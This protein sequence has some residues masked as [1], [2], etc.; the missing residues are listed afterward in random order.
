MPESQRGL[1]PSHSTA[2]AKFLKGFHIAINAR[3]D[4]DVSP[5]H[6]LQRIADSSGSKYSIHNEPAQR[7]QAPTPV[8]RINRPSLVAVAVL[9]RALTDWIVRAYRTACD[10]TD[11][12][13]PTSYSC[14]NCVYFTN[15]RISRDP[16]D[17]GEFGRAK[18]TECDSKS[19]IGCTRRCS[20]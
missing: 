3:S 13:R 14:R 4:A 2:V 16:Q 9:T 10:C 19:F 6:I 11:S 5:S 20:Y 17:S 7:Y 8:V 1:F 15:K 18:S 12:C